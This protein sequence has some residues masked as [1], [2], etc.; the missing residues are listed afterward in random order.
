MRLELGEDTLDTDPTFC[1]RY[2][3]RSICEMLHE[4]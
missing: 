2:W 4:P 1:F 3:Q